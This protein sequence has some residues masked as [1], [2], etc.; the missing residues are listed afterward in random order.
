MRAPRPSRPCCGPARGVPAG[1]GPP[2]PGG[3]VA[4]C[5]GC[6]L[7]YGRMC[8]R[9]A[10]AS[11]PAS[12]QRSP[13]ASARPPLGCWGCPWRCWGCQSTPFGVGNSPCSPWGLQLSYRQ[14]KRR[15]PS[16]GQIPG[17]KSL[18]LLGPRAFV[19][20]KLV[21]P[22]APFSRAIRE[23]GGSRALAIKT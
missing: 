7:S 9:T 4:R 11:R 16:R 3:W 13:M 20:H 12:C 10:A 1:P 2:Q 17:I 5:E 18:L 19:L 23:Q 21:V 14:L 22:V 8:A 15:K 6:G